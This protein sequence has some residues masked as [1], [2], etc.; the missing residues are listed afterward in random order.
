MCLPEKKPKRNSAP[1]RDLQI[2]I[3][4]WLKLCWPEGCGIEWGHC[5]NGGRR[6]TTKIRGK[7]IPLDAI[8]LKRMG[9]KAGWPDLFF[10]WKTAEGHFAAG[11]IELKIDTS[12]SDDQRDFSFRWQALGGRWAVC[13]TPM[14]VYEALASWGI[15]PPY[16]PPLALQRGGR[17]TE[18]Q[19]ALGWGAP[20]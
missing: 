18:Y 13:R 12:L 2:C 1:E 10:F 11:A 20:V 5:P 3:A 15:T 17:Q 4:E 6:P 16:K 9:T 8:L 7:D 14:A 19:M